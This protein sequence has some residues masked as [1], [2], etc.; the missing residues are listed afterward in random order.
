M[1]GLAEVGNRIYRLEVPVPGALVPNVSYFIADGDGALVE[2]GPG[3]AV[4]AIQ[5]A[6]ERLGL[7]ELAYIIPTHIHVDHAG[8]VGA[9][10]KIY[11]K[12]EV[13]AH[14]RG[15]K[16]LVNPARLVATTKRIYGNDFERRSGPVLPVPESRIKIVEDGDTLIV[17][18]RTLQVIHAPG[19]S[20]DHFGI[21]DRSLS[22][23]FCGEALGLPP[24]LLP[25]VAPYA[26]DQ[27]AY[28]QTIEKLRKLKPRTIFNSHGG[29]ETVPGDA[30]STAAE[31]TRIYG[32][33][34][35]EGIRH[36]DSRADI[37]RRFAADVKRRFGLPFGPE[38]SELFVTGY[39][40]D[41]EKKGLL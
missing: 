5:S 17:G 40:M 37:A 31:N 38:G 7:S 14:P 10:A 26:F 22:G 29:V 16:H 39:A 33:M 35:L 15:A 3:A 6:I 9:L 30:F 18:A 23:L 4:P 32:K 13:L 21:L 11:P 27:E 24:H 41:Y 25:S 34:V 20:P 12:A 1:Q 8:G 28:L 2:P 19:H 36:G